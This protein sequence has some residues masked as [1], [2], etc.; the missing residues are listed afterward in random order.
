MKAQLFLVTF[1]LANLFAFSQ[2]TAIPDTNF[3][4]ALSSYDDIANDGQV[5]TA[6]INTITELF[7]YNENIDDLTGIQDFAAL[8]LL[9]CND[10]NLTSLDISNNTALTKLY[11]NFNSL[12]SLDISNNL[13]LTYLDFSNN[14]ITNI[15]VS[16]H[17]LLTELICSN[18]S[19]TNL[20]ESSLLL[21]FL[22]GNLFD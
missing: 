21:N 19:L 7:I 14:G 1:L 11:C 5:P 15:D 9:D 17:N 22:G 8:T 13:L 16:N 3:E 2:Y 12:T 20:D 4:N 6:N 18:N 10:N